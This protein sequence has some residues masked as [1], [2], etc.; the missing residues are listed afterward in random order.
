MEKLNKYVL[1]S[2]AAKILGVSANTLRT[3]ARE[4]KIPVYQNPANGYRMFRKS[5]LEA[6]LKQVADSGKNKTQA[7]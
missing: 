5:D 7:K 6:F 4:G 2:E 1:T 3:W